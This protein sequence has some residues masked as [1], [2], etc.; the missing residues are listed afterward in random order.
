MLKK[1]KM[2]GILILLKINLKT[3]GTKSGRF[4]AANQA[5]S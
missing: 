4:N 2:S 3:Y 5:G 1:A